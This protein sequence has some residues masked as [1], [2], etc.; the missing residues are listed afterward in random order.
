VRLGL[1]DGKMVCHTCGGELYYGSWG[2]KPA[3]RCHE[4]TKHGMPTQAS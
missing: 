2:Q 1:R 4:N 3:W